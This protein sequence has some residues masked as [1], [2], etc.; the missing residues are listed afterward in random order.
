MDRLVGWCIMYV[1][2]SVGDLELDWV[3]WVELRFLDR[4]LHWYLHAVPSLIIALILREAK[5]TWMDGCAWLWTCLLHMD[6]VEFGW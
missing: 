6:P 1:G 4:K 2:H 3:G 5:R